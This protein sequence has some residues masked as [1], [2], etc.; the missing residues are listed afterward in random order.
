MG[1]IHAC[2]DEFRRLLEACG[3]RAEDEVVSIGDLVDRGPDPL[4]VVEFFMNDPNA[5][6]ILGN[7]EDK[8]IRTRT[9]ELQPALSQQIAKLQ[10][11]ASYDRRSTGS[12][13][14]PSSWS[15]T[16]T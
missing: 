1:D 4:P 5:A 2:W 15:A 11:G 6:A 3:R 7:H 10:M 16:A 8:H 13:R 9:G 14:C 12:R